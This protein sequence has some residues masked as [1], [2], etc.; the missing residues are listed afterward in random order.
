MDEEAGEG[1]LLLP[2]DA[3][4]AGTDTEAKGEY[5]GRNVL[6]QDINV[7]DSQVM[8]QL[9]EAESEAQALREEIASLKSEIDDYQCRESLTEQDEEH[10]QEIQVVLMEKVSLLDE[11]T[12]RIAKLMEFAGKGSLAEDTTI[13][14]DEEEE[15]FPDDLLPRVV[16]CSSWDDMM[17]KVVVCMD[18]KKPSAAKKGESDRDENGLTPEQREALEQERRCMA[19]ERNRLQYQIACMEGEMR[20]MMREN[21]MLSKKVAQLKTEME[22]QPPF[23]FEMSVSATQP[24]GVGCP[25]PGNMDAGYKVMGPN[26]N[27]NYTMGAALSPGA[28]FQGKLAVSGPPPQ[29]P[30]GF[31]GTGGCSGP[32]NYQQSVKQPASNLPC[33]GLTAIPG[34][35]I[36]CPK[37]QPQEP[38]GPNPNDWTTMI[39][40]YG[41]KCRKDFN[42]SQG[43]GGGGGGCG[44]CDGCPGCG[45]GGGGGGCCGGADGGHG[46]GGCDGCGGGGGG[47][48][49]GCGG[50]AGGQNFLPPGMM[51]PPPV[52]V[53]F[54]VNVQPTGTQG[55]SCNRPSAGGGGAPT[56]EATELLNNFK[57]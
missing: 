48:C 53:N 26:A 20:V 3:G 37:L 49:G 21:D 35:T 4:E 12:K 45:G 43:G 22:N 54:K 38:P 27:G 25:K 2:E 9:K 24:P 33:G 19:E 52:D 1:D 5:Y 7:T 55:G 30:P 15:G 46:M 36:P 6:E 32:Q 39:P 31:P 41:K 40:P 23:E 11:L 14:D 50:G 29:F 8:I 28:E 42:T 57:K 13:L 10:L 44:G 34:K 56:T 51:K 16:I 18:M 47:G 17:P